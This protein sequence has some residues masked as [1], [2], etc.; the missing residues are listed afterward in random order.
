[1][2][3][4]NYF[5]RI[6]L[7]SLFI[8]QTSY[9]FSINSIKSEDPTL[10][11][12]GV[13]AHRGARESHPENTLSAFKEAVRLGAQMVEFDVRMTKD[14]KLIIMHD[15]SIDRTTD[16]TG[17]VEDLTWEEVKKLDAGS[18][19]SKEFKGERV[20]LLDEALDVFPKT[21]WL[22]VHLKGDKA[23]GAAVARTILDKNR[24][25][26]SIVAC[27]AASAKG[28]KQVSTAIMMCNMERTPKRKK[29]VK[30]TV[31]GNFKALQ[32]LSKR[33]DANFS[34]DI[35]ELKR[36]AIKI[37]YFY[38]NSPEAGVAL[39]QK[40]VDFVL[41]DELEK[42]LKAAEKIGIERSH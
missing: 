22:N 4:I 32:F 6:I 30:N 39:L 11:E 19:K 28:V 23:L 42:M 20:P 3:T 34:T 16:G 10:P 38:S 24:V 41:T 27:N 15:A 12:R 33:D 37:N 2:T 35:N 25:H 1:V 21:I 7:F 13:C 18:W 31:K 14:G 40:G 17:L 8:L 36:H 29:Y 26:Q 5:K 9:I